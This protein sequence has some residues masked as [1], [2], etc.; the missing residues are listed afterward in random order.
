MSKYVSVCTLIAPRAGPSVARG[1]QV[2]G[3]TSEPRCVSRK[4]R[5]MF[6]R[7]VGTN[8]EVRHR[9]ISRACPSAIGQE[10]LAGQEIRL[11]EEG[12]LLADATRECG[13]QRF[14][15]RVADRNFGRWWRCSGGYP[16]KHLGSCEDVPPNRHGLLNRCPSASVVAQGDIN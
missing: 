13:I 10:A 3:S 5:Q 16:P 1:S 9:G 11:P 15:G 8:V 4:Q 2:S 7:S 6:N 12:I 14:D